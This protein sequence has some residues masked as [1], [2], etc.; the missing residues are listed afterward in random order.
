MTWWQCGLG[1]Y[2]GGPKCLENIGKVA[3]VARV[4]EEDLEGGRKRQDGN[5]SASLWLVTAW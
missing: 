3:C 4:E 1:A 2:R 5:S